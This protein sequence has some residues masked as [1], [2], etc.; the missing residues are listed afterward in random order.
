MALYHES[1]GSKWVGGQQC[2]GTIECKE[3]ACA[4]AHALRRDIKRGNKGANREREGRFPLWMIWQSFQVT[5]I[6]EGLSRWLSD[7]SIAITHCKKSGHLPSVF[8]QIF[9]PAA[10][11]S[12]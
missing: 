10:S 1:T 6:D 5:D 11:S 8:P 9:T 2:Q 4:Y 3:G 12:F 7:S